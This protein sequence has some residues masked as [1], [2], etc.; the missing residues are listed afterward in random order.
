MMVPDKAHGQR[1]AIRPINDGSDVILSLLSEMLLGSVS[2][3]TARS[4]LSG[5]SRANGGG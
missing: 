4:E 3:L 1:T 5:G 2:E